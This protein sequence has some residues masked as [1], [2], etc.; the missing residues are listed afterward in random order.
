MPHTVLSPGDTDKRGV[1]LVQVSGCV[2]AGALR[3]GGR[4]PIDGQ[5]LVLADFLC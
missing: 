2:T 5:A 4:V 3:T 1:G